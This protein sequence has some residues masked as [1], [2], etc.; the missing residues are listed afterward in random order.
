MLF[1]GGCWLHT[2]FD[3][4]GLTSSTQDMRILLCSE[5]SFNNNRI[6]Q[7]G[8]R[9][10]ILEITLLRKHPH[11][12]TAA[13]PRRQWGA[14]RTQNHKEQ[15]SFLE[16]T[17]QGSYQFSAQEEGFSKHKREQVQGTDCL[18]GPT[19]SQVGG[20]PMSATHTGPLQERQKG[21]EGMGCGRAK[22][23]CLARDHIR[24]QD[25]SPSSVAPCL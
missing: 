22:G 23:S 9:I 13:L 2:V 21:G 4:W 10:K 25:S 19:G 8:A 16:L 11:S 18:G 6:L 12:F 3:V 17:L 1:S 7:D 14:F 15:C 5:G 20:D 24:E